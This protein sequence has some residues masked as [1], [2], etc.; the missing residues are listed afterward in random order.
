[1]WLLSGSL[2]VGCVGSVALLAA[3]LPWRQQANAAT[4]VHALALNLNHEPIALAGLIRAGRRHARF[5]RGV[6]F[7]LWFPPPAVG[8][9]FGNPALFMKWICTGCHADAPAIHLG[10]TVLPF[11]WPR[12]ANLLFRPHQQCA[13]AHTCNV[14]TQEMPTHA[15]ETSMAATMHNTATAPTPQMDCPSPPGPTY[16]PCPSSSPSCPALQAQKSGSYTLLVNK[17]RQNQHAAP[18]VASRL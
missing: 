14:S 12:P 3:R 13:H 8:A 11:N 18:Q 2:C 17:L 15:A 4:L 1:M 16:S 5:A 7:A 9:L 6:W 10:M